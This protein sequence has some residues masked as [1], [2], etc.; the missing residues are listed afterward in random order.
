[1]RKDALTS[2]DHS[3]IINNR[4]QQQISAFMKVRHERVLEQDKH[5]T[6]SRY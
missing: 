3:D 2:V 4:A 1:M 5:M 6:N